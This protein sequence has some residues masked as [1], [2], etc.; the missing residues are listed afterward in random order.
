M[1]P[2]KPTIIFVPGGWHGS[3]AFSTVRTSLESHGYRTMGIS[4]PSVGAEPPLKTW[5][6]D[7]EAIRSAIRKVVDEEGGDVVLAMHSYGALPSSEAAKG[8]GKTEREKEGRKGGVVRLVYICAALIDVGNS[9]GD[10]STVEDADKRWKTDVMFS[11]PRPRTFPLSPS[12]SFTALHPASLFHE[13][14]NSFPSPCLLQNPT[15][16]IAFPLHLYS[17]PQG[18]YITALNPAHYFYNDL[19]ASTAE[20]WASKLKHHSLPTLVSPVTYTAWRHI[21][22]TYLLCEADNAFP[23]PMQEAMVETAKAAGVDVTVE[24]CKAGHSPFLSVPEV[25]VGL[26]RRAAGEDGVV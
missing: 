6:P 10:P 11:L 19:P 7:V 13:R 20:H 5:D 1:P 23:L 26:L 15:G 9:L 25:V 12:P 16:S 2:P 4:L 22:V 14:R 21:P 24:R 17:L 8:Y 3:E 18:D